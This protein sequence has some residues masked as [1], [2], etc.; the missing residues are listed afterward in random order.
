[1]YID[2]PHAKRVGGQR[3]NSRVYDV[4]TWDG[5]V[6]I[7]NFLYIMYKH[8]HLKSHELGEA[9]HVQHSGLLL[10]RDDVTLMN[11]HIWKA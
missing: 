11:H 10:L 8:I 1:M 2:L 7:P 4:I 3:L 5:N 6:K 9:L